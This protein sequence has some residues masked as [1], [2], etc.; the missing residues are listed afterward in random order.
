MPR[1]I[2]LPLLS[3]SVPPPSSPGLYCTPAP[4]ARTWR[5]MNFYLTLLG[6]Y[7][8]NCS[9]TLSIARQ[10]PGPRRRALGCPRA[11]RRGGRRHENDISF[12][13]VIFAPPN[14]TG[15][16]PKWHAMSLLSVCVEINTSRERLASRVPASTPA[17]AHCKVVVCFDPK[18]AISPTN[19]G[20]HMPRSRATSRRL[21]DGSEHAA[22]L[23]GLF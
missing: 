7:L 18:L 21:P 22:T 12:E 1:K 6:S 17:A 15:A 14:E 10:F 9:F 13:R 23:G 5:Q 16:A 11:P 20:T 19:H 3:S 2:I 8:N 4:H